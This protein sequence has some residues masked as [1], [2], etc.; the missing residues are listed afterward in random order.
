MTIF[1]C[2]A[3]SC[4]CG[5]SRITYF[6]DTKAH[7]TYSN[8]YF[9][10]KNRFHLRGAAPTVSAWLNSACVPQKY[11]S[12]S[13]WRWRW[14][15]YGRPKRRTVLAQQH[16]LHGPAGSN[17]QEHRCENVGFHKLREVCCVIIHYKIMFLRCKYFLS[18]EFRVP[19]QLN[20]C[21]SH[22]LTCVTSTPFLLRGC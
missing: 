15:Y 18:Y 5:S 19:E 12:W 10:S 8:S 1:R 20:C 17:L 3:L 16:S 14:R 11:Y 6:L 2:H 13:A 4:H 21:I 9:A 7:Y 22:M